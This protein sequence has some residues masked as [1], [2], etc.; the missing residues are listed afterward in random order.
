MLLFWLICM[1]VYHDF[2]FGTR[3]KINVSWCGFGSGLMIRIRPDPDPKHWFFSWFFSIKNIIF[4]NRILLVIYELLIHACVLKKKVTS[5][6]KKV[7]YSCNFGRFLCEFPTFFTYQPGSGSTD[8]WYFFSSMK[9]LE[10][11]IG[12]L[13]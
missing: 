11:E 5:R 10:T 6:E 9:P 2:F 12:H 3:I 7:W 8:F 1:P 4:K 13:N